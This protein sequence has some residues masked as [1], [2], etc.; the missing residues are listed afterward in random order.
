MSFLVSL[1]SRIVYILVFLDIILLLN[2][3]TSN[4]KPPIYFLSLYI[5]I[6]ETVHMNV[7]LH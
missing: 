6:F 5:S 3:L 4:K 7:I 2:I 1:V